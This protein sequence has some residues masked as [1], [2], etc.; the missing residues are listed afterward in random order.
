MDRSQWVNAIAFIVG[1]PFLAIVLGEIV[2]RLEHRRN[3]GWAKLLGTI[4]ILVLPSLAIWVVMSHFLGVPRESWSLKVIESLV[5]CSA[6]VALLN[7]IEILFVSDPKAQYQPLFTVPRLFVQIARLLAVLSVGSYVLGNIWQVNLSNIATALGVGSLVI[8]LALQNTLSNL[9]S[10]FLLLFDSPFKVGDWIRFG[11]IEGQVIDLNWRS[12][13]LKTLDRDL[14]V[15]PNSVLDGEKIYNYHSGDRLHAE[16][17]LMG[18]S[19]DDPP[20]RIKQ[21]L[22]SAAKATDRILAKP[23]PEVRTVSYDDFTITYEVKYFIDDFQYVEEI[24][25]EFRTRIFYAAKRNGLK[26]PY[27]IRVL[28]RDRQSTPRREEALEQI[29]SFLQSLPYFFSLDSDTI[30]N[31]A[32][33]VTIQFYGIGDRVVREGESDDGLYIIQEGK[34]RLFVTD[35]QGRSKE[36]AYLSQED[37]FGETALLPGELSLVTGIVTEDLT[38]LVLS[39]EIVAEL[40]AGSARFAKQIYQFI[41]ER[42]KQIYLTKGMNS[43]NGQKTRNEVM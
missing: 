11:D 20:N 22:K 26:I 34:I 39:C 9:V 35:L 29:Q 8:A 14:L 5:G 31:L 4:R 40:I 32:E 38:V 27:P 19:Y 10:G 1:F 43:L 6:I 16:R 3:L 18:F 23:S 42:K 24:R 41:E 36:V 15:V 37:F 17:Y 2:D 21:V 12:V 30:A 25:N 7:L 28:Q 33:R 13:R